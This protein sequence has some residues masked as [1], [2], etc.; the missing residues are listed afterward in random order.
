MDYFAVFD[1]GGSAIK[2]SLMDET[3]AFLEKSSVATPKDGLDS[4]LD[5]IDSTVKNFQKNHEISGIALSMPGAVDVDSG[6][7]K[8]ITAIEYIHG[9]NIKEMIQERTQLR[10]ELENDANCAGLAEGWIGAAKGI[11][12][13][14][15]IIIGT[16]I[17]GALVLDQ[18]IRHGKNLF[19]GE[20][21]YMLLEDYLNQPIGESWS[22]LAATGGLIIQVAKRKGLEPA[23]L[24]GRK[25]FKMADEGDQEV[26][27]E[28]EKFMKRLAVGI[29]NLQYIIDPE[30]IL[31]G[32]A[33]SK[34]EGLI[35]QIN[36]KLKLMKPNHEC[37]DI[38]VEPCRFGNDSNLIGALYHFLR[39]TANLSNQ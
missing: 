9:P 5:I 4:F 21:G 14:I 24:D 39:R 10:V 35:E 6:F 16:G 28:I 30:K 17:G 20:F 32:G 23:A 38:H 25:I 1:V 2:Y 34:R 12:D 19:G 33:I 11:K 26:Q 29:Y 37:L 27:D 22:A 15:C 8:G 13:Y 31:I 7:I 3:G 18:K 36:E